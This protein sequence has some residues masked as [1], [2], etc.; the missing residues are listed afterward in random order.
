[1]TSAALIAA[2][3]LIA[4]SLQTLRRLRAEADDA[5]GK[6]KELEGAIQKTPFQLRKKLHRAL[7]LE[8]REN[9]NP[10]PT[11]TFDAAGKSAKIL[12]P[13]E[14]IFT[15]AQEEGMG[16]TGTCEGNGDCGLCAIAVISGENNLTPKGQ[17]EDDLLK[18][19]EFPANARLSCQS[20]ATGDVVVDFIQS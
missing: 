5:R 10:F 19:M 7:L 14:T 8:N 11:V 16:L 4:A 1:M 9:G 20:R 2:I 3:V 15:V 13:W 17:S 18:K 12:F 6:L